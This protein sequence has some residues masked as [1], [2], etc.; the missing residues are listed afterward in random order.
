MM[1]SHDLVQMKGTISAGLMAGKAAFRGASQ[2]QEIGVDLVVAP[3]GVEITT[4]EQL[5]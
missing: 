1:G 2:E 4:T 5:L 3:D